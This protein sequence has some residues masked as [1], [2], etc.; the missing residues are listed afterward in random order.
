MSAL[1]DFALAC[2]VRR[3][4]RAPPLSY[5]ADNLFPIG[6]FLG[7][8]EN[9]SE[10]GGF[11]VGGGRLSAVHGRGL[12]KARLTA[13]SWAGEPSVCQELLWHARCEVT[14]VL[15]MS[16]LKLS[17]GYLFRAINK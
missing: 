15:K 17:V 12:S 1:V 6:N 8:R 13:W 7:E 10:L 14:D 5:D 11:S 16:S 3:G 2:L 9:L 4:V